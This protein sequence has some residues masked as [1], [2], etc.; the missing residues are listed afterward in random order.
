MSKITTPVGIAHYPY[1]SK[2]DTKFNEKGEYKVALSI[3]KA[4][5]KPIIETINAV[6]LDGMK[7]VKEAKPNAKIKK[8]PLP[9][10]DEVDEEGMETGNV[11]VK[12]KSKYKPQV[13]DSEGNVMAEHNVWGGSELKVGGQAVFY[14]SPS[15]GCGVTLRLGG[16]QI[17][18]YV[19]GSSG[20]DSFGFGKEE[21]GYVATN[22]SAVPAATNIQEQVDVTDATP[23][24]AA[25]KAKPKAVR[26]PP[27]VEEPK[28]AP[29][30]NS[31]SLADEIAALVGE[32]DD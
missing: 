18:Q 20:A 4:E 5:A 7:K 30:A 22:G 31:G 10:E 14:S 8:A 29:V 1:I 27:P 24:V 2:P 9:F 26:S 21:S 6:L 17:I 12:F 16:V 15:I 28:A 3:P 11:R 13:F 23:A 19:E 25:V 32:T